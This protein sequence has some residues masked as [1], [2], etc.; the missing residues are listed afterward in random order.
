M[1]PTKTP[2]RIE[3]IVAA[4][5]NRA[6]I[7]R[8]GPNRFWQ[9]LVWD[10]DSDRVIP[11]HWLKGMVRVPRCD[12]T[13]D[14]R[15]LV[16]CANNYANIWKPHKTPPGL[17]EYRSSGWTAICRPPFYTALALWFS[18]DSWFGGGICNGNREIWLNSH[19]S[20]EEHIAP[21]GPVAVRHKDSLSSWDE[22]IFTMRQERH[23]WVHK[24][25]LVVGDKNPNHEQ[26]IH[27]LMAMR[28]DPK[29][30]WHEE[31]WVHAQP[32]PI[33]ITS[34]KNIAPGK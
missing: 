19:S 25:E 34:G 27:A 14:G 6:V 26:A 12:V 16:L 4:E 21:A 7:F 17:P 10:L 2:C 13:R 1:P 20:W 29:Q 22:P 28:S 32:H 24:R 23:G 9:Q 5:A 31:V 33:T 8:R 3:G 15:Y 18:G 11:G 30:V